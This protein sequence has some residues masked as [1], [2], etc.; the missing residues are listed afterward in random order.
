M[1]RELIVRLNAILK[2]VI[3]DWVPEYRAVGV[4]LKL[5]DGTILS[6]N[7]GGYAD[8]VTPEL[9]EQMGQKLKLMTTQLLRAHGEIVD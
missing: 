6:F 1:N 3:R 5:I 7:C 9:L 8:R 2:M 4:P